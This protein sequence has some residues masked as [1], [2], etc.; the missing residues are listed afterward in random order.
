MRQF[1]IPTTFVTHAKQQ[2]QQQ[3]AALAAM[4]CLPVESFD[5]DKTKE[6]MYSKHLRKATMK[7]PKAHVPRWKTMALK[8]PFARGIHMGFPKWF[9]TTTNEIT[10]WPSAVINSDAHTA[11]NMYKQIMYH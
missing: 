3:H 4:F 11:P 10:Y 5:C 7:A 2:V 1:S 8:K 9:T 6:Q